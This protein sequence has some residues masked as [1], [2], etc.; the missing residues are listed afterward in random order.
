MDLFCEIKSLIKVNHNYNE[1]NILHSRYLGPAL[2]WYEKFLNEL[3]ADMT[4]E[5]YAFDEYTKEYF[6][7]DVFM[8][9]AEYNKLLTLLLYKKNIILQGAPGVGKTF[10]AKRFAYSL[11]GKKDD[12]YIEMV[13][14]HQS[15]SYEDFIM[16]YKPV[17]EGFELKTGSFYN[18][19]KKAEKDTFVSVMEEV[20]WRKI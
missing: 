16:G 17:D 1:I 5:I 18:F 11:I 20:I 19:C 7:Q 15:Y 14:F 3:C 6:L 8:D 13:Q 9:E 12:R 10:L 2:N 4:E